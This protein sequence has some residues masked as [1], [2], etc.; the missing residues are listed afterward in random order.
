[1]KKNHFLITFLEVFD[2][3]PGNSSSSARRRSKQHPALPTAAVVLRTRVV[4]WCDGTGRSPTVGFNGRY[5][6]PAATSNSHSDSRIKIPLDA[7]GKE[8]RR[9]ESLPP[10]RIGPR[11]ALRPIPIFQSTRRF[12][13]SP[14]RAEQNCYP[15]VWRVPCCQKYS[16]AQHHARGQTTELWG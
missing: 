6:H 15:Q 2:Q 13:H 5:W 3:N 1:M 10:L 9:V 12:N 7:E 14:C 16:V 4:S 11:L 8:E